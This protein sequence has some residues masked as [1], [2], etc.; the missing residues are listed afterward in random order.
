MIKAQC[1]TCG[2]QEETSGVF[3]PFPKNG[4]PF[5]RPELPEGWRRVEVP[6]P[7]GSARERHLCLRCVRILWDLFRVEYED[8]R[9][10]ALESC[11]RCGHASGFHA[12]RKGCTLTVGGRA[13]GCVLSPV[14]STDEGWVQSVDGVPH[15]HDF[16]DGG[17]LCRAEDCY[18]SWGEVQR[19]R[20]EQG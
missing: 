19:A 3:L 5:F 15:E 11:V 18:V 4:L 6:M 2:T 8:V 10:E 20:A 12:G 17:S 1:D 14:E 7:D 16:G 9:P 13:C